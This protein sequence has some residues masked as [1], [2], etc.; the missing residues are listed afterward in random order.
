[1]AGDETGRGLAPIAPRSYAAAAV[2]VAATLWLLIEA[3]PVLEPLTIAVLLW[4]LLNA[5]AG[6]FARALRG[7][8]AVARGAE[9][10]AAALTVLIAIAGLSVLVSASLSGFRANLPSYEANLREMLRQAGQA[11]GMGEALDLQAL[12]QN[13]QVTDIALSLAGTAVGFVGALVVILV[14]VLFLF[15][16]AGRAG[17]KL[18]AL[19]PEQGA[20]DALVATIGRINR[21]IETY[22]GV[23]CIIGAAQA[24]PTFALLTIVG[25]DG[26]AF[27]AVVI[28]VTSFVPTVGS[29]IGIIFPATVALVQ[30]P[31]LTP[32]LMTLPLLAVIQIAGSNWLEPRLM[33]T[34]LNLSPLVILIAIFAGGAVWGITGALVA[35]P[36]LSVA[37]IVFA[38]LPSMRPVAILLSSDGRV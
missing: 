19:A 16:E 10:L 13:I 3:R 12:T 34:S 24:I 2:G 7:P 8:A 15:V 37:T 27:W 22:L 21:E 26:A 6:V 20:H 28:F 32:F 29:L 18:H 1:M 36:A 31:T 17:D 33:G 4:F 35:V 25:V 9:K 23:K 38:Q 14:Y 5:V 30:F 11:V